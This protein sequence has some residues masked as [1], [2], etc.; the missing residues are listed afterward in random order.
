[1]TIRFSILDQSIINPGE[2]PSETLQNTVE[3]AQ[4]AEQLGFHRFWVAEHHN[5]DEIAGAA[6]EVLLGYIAAKTN[7]I[8]LASGGV[9]L[10]HYSPY[11]VAEQF[12]VLENLAPGRVSLG[13]GKAPGGF[14]PAT[15]ALQKDFAKPV[16]TFDAKL[17]ELVELISHKSTTTIEAKPLPETN[18]EIFLLGG[19]VASAKQAA[20]LGISFVFAYFINGEESVLKEARATFD[21]FQINQDTSFQLAPIVVVAETKSAADRHIPERESIKVEL[22]DGRRVN[23]GSRKQAEAYVKDIDQSYRFITQRIGAITGTKQ[24]VGGEIKRLS[25]K[26]NIQDFVIL[27][28][29]KSTEIKRYSYQL[30]SESIKE[31]VVHG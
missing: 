8:K 13:V 9:M 11:K 4:L 31:E 26:Y 21:Q 24:E 29:I 15:D 10:Q 20:E 7:S 18:P 14:Q 27:T 22:A 19:S 17:E 28:P 2:N 25:E 30:L 3:L 16:R 12:H 6:P 5:S 23:L 1:M